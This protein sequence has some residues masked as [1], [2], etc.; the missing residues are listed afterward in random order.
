MNLLQKIKYLKEIQ[1]KE[2]LNGLTAKL[3]ENEEVCKEIL[4]MLDNTSVAVEKNQVE[5]STTSLYLVLN[6]KILI[7]NMKQSFV[8]IQTIAH[9]CIHSIQNRK[10]LLFHF[11]LANAVQFYFIFSLFLCFLLKQEVVTWSIFASFV[12]ASLILFCVRYLLEKDAMLR[13]KD[14]A[15]RYLEQQGTLTQTEIEKI[16]EEYT[17]MNKIGVPLYRDCL[18]GKMLWKTVLLLVIVLFL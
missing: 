18:I 11:F 12:L 4:K 15:K 7:G 2:E 5:D 3:P 6:N 16:T 8:R 1:N 9:E 13:A 14:L 10:T 17:K